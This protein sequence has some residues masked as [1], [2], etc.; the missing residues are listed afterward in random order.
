[1]QCM[2]MG[3]YDDF[4]CG[5]NLVFGH[6]VLNAAKKTWWFGCVRICWTSIWSIKMICKIELKAEG[7]NIAARNLHA[8]LCR[9]WNVRRHGV[10]K[11]FWWMNNICQQQMMVKILFEFQKTQTR[12]TLFCKMANSWITHFLV[13]N[14]CMPGNGRGLPKNWCWPCWH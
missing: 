12:A 14:K 7:F 13:N 2:S 10:A 4:W 9:T 3:K 5:Y 1:M 6:F 11:C 8:T